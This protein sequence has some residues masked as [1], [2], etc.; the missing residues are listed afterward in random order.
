MKQELAPSFVEKF[1][2]IFHVD[3]NN[4]SK[5]NTIDDKIQAHSEKLFREFKEA[6]AAVTKYQQVLDE[7]VHIIHK[8]QKKL[9]ATTTNNKYGNDFGL[10]AE[11]FD[12]E[13]HAGIFNFAAYY[14]IPYQI[15]KTPYYVL[16]K[17]VDDY[18]KLINESIK[19]GIPWDFSIYDPE[20]L[21]GAIEDHKHNVAVSEKIERNLHMKNRIA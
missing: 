18:K 15:D 12:D 11:A 5:C 14:H 16:E 3:T 21:K 7:T 17:K 19:C 6:L 1:N 13:I 20:G 4:S 10:Y 8:S 9:A 2:Q